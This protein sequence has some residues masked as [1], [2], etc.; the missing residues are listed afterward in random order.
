MDKHLVI[1]IFLLLS[2][3][4]INLFNNGSFLFIFFI[5]SFLLDILLYLLFPVF[6]DNLI[7]LLSVFLVEGPVVVQSRK[8]LVDRIHVI[9]KDEEQQHQ[10][11]QEAH[12]DG[13]CPRADAPVESPL[14]RLG[15]LLQVIID[16]FVQDI[17]VRV[18][19]VE[20]RLKA[21]EIPGP[22]VDEV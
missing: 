15:I 6:S 8:H 11:K 5:V 14:E 7:S 12:H 10:D 21:V 22:G 13:Y 19:P 9:R 16:S 17:D 3:L 1:L 20:L 2:F 4:L 18:Q